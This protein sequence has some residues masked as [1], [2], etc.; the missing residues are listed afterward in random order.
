MNLDLVRIL[1]CVAVVGI[2]SVRVRDELFYNLAYYICCFAVPAFFMASGYTLLNRDCVRPGY[3]VRKIVDLLRLAVCWPV[4]LWLCILAIDLLCGRAPRYN[5]ASLPTMIFASFLQRGYFGQLWYL[6]TTMLVYACLPALYWLRDRIGLGRIWACLAALGVAQ[7]VV[8]CFVGRPLQED[9]PQMLR[10][11]T[12][13]QY[14]LLG[15]LFGAGELPGPLRRVEN[16]S[17][18]AHTVCL[19]AVT[20]G[21]AFYQNW[22]ARNVLHVV[23]AEHFYDSAFTVLWLILLF[24]WVMKLPVSE[25]ARPTI[26]ALSSLTLGVYIIHSL[27]IIAIRRVFAWAHLP[28]SLLLCI[29]SLA[30]SVLG[31][32]ALSKIPILRDMIRLKGGKRRLE[33]E[34]QRLAG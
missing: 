4:L 14:F 27:V 12:F 32:F 19:L 34:R 11:W 8:S 22:M 30:L 29:C 16:L 1:A 31:A 2:H 26:T 3:V 33:A 13:L 6:G 28:A 23:S 24:S 18:K 7:T 17:L 10:L 15:G 9:I 5:V 25:R 20:V 21:I